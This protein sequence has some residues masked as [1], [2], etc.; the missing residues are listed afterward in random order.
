M[1]TQDVVTLNVSKISVVGRWP[2]HVH[3]FTYKTL[4]ISDK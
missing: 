1:H 2:W 3:A 4:T